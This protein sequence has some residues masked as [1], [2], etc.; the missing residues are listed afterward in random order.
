MTPGLFNCIITVVPKVG[1]EREKKTEK[2]YGRVQEK[3]KEAW[4]SFVS[5][6]PQRIITGLLGQ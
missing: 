1:Q 4:N 6:R 2:G 3:W 5:L